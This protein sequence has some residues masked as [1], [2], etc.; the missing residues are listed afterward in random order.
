MGHRQPASLKNTAGLALAF[1]A[2]GK[3]KGEAKAKAASGNSGGADN[4][5]KHKKGAPCKLF[6]KNDCKHGSSC[7]FSHKKGSAAPA[8][9][10]GKKQKK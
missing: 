2:K 3:G 10:S 1:I 8:A 4:I 7:E 5:K 6:A 9:E